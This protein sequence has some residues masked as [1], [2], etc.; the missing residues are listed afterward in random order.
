MKGYFM[1][2]NVSCSKFGA[3]F[4]GIKK[5]EGDVQGQPPQEFLDKLKEAGIPEDIIAKGRQT[6]EDF[7]KFNNIVLPNPP[8]PPAGAK[9]QGA[10]HANKHS[11]LNRETSDKLKTVMEENNIPF[12]GNLKDDI[13]AVKTAIKALDG[14]EAKSLKDKL[15]LAGL[16]VEMVDDKEAV[17]KA[18]CD[19]NQLGAVNKQLFVGKNVKK[20]I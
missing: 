12:T 17:K 10:A 16:P 19:L 11:I 18:F 6:V 1:F 9:S 7:A 4:K 3:N 2:Q 15:Q 5:P 14:D 13:A 20:S 8:E